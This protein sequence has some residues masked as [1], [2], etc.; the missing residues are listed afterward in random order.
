MLG[1]SLL[2][3]GYRCYDP[4]LS[5]FNALCLLNQEH[6]TTLITKGELL[7]KYLGLRIF[8]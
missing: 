8:S 2:Q 1:F 4:A 7:K 3:H 6:V 5:G